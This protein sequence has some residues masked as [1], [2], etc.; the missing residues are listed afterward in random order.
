MKLLAL[1]V[2]IGV[3]LNLA[4]AATL[5]RGDKITFF[6]QVT[7]KNVIG[8]VSRVE[9]NQTVVA[10]HQVFY[11]STNK[12]LKV[13]LGP[14]EFFGPVQ[15]MNGYSVGQ[16]V[17]FVDKKGSGEI[18]ALFENGDAEVTVG[19]FFG[20]SFLIFK[21]PIL[22]SLSSLNNCKCNC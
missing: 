6:D 1:I 9:D 22:M 11:E 16:K 7:Q 21:R 17:C 18:T 19:D 5:K 12:F 20:I 2:F 4:A 14:S 13:K 10:F 3:T 8:E 15:S